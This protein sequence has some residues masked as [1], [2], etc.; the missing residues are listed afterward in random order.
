LNVKQA[1]ITI[2]RSLKWR[3]G[4][5]WYT[6]PTK[7]EKTITI[8]LT[9][10][11]IERLAEHR[12]RQLA[13]KL[14]AGSHW[15]N[16]GFIFTDAIGRPLRPGAVARLHKEI[17]EAAGLPDT[18]TPKVSRHSCASAML[19]AGKS[20]KVVQERLGHSSIKDHR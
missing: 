18:F 4:P 6:T 19:N 5:Q 9:P 16:A 12:K 8:E 13:M 2:Q 11:F 7:R 10:Y 3:K 17:L 15:T 20:L 14:K 1:E